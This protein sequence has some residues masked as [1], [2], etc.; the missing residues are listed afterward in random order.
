MERQGLS[1]AYIGILNA[2]TPVEANTD[3]QVC[4]VDQPLCV[5]VSE[6]AYVKYRKL[7][8]V[9]A[10]DLYCLQTTSWD[11]LDVGF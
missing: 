6:E 1:K 10:R 9:A 8:T 11:L 4:K 3:V 7:T 5:N 2:L